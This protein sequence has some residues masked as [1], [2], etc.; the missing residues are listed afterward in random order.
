LARRQVANF[1]VA[2]AVADEDDFVDGCHEG[3]SKYRCK[4]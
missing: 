3:I 1:R 2:A 4:F